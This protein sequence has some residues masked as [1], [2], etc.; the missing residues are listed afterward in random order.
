MRAVV[1]IFIEVVVYRLRKLEMANLFGGLSIACALRLPV[2][3]IAYRT[4]FIFLLNVLLYLNNDY[5]DA[6]QDADPTDHCDRADK[7]RFLHAHRKEALGAQWA[8]VVCLVV[9]ALAYDKWLLLPAVLGGGVCVAYSARLK[10]IAFLD[11]LA[12][13]LLGALLPACAFPIQRR[14]G[15]ALATA[16][17]LIC[18]IFESIQVVRD[19]ESDR[20]A[21]HDTTGVRLGEKGSAWLTRALMAL[22]SIYLAALIHPVAAVLATVALVLPLRHAHIER[23]WTRVKLAYGVA[24]LFAISWVFLR[25]ETAGLLQRISA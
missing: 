15:W 3:D 2:A 21:G 18:G 25:G 23:D 11:I 4:T 5:L 17:G 20:R 9:M 8:L 14:A 1:Q 7:A 10:A 12:M 6:A 16:L 22:S 13:T 19:L 24:W